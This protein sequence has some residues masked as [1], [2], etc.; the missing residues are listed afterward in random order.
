MDKNLFLY[1]N[2]YSTKVQASN[3]VADVLRTAEM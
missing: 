1:L 3:V 2:E